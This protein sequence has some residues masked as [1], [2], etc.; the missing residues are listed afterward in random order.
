MPVGGCQ[1]GGGEMGGLASGS[2]QPESDS[3][4]DLTAD[5]NAERDGSCESG[6]PDLGVGPRGHAGGLL[7]RAEVGNR[8]LSWW[9][10]V[11]GWS[12]A[13][14]VVPVGRIHGGAGCTRSLSPPRSREAGS[15]LPGP[16][17]AALC[18]RHADPGTPAPPPGTALSR[19]TQAWCLKHGTQAWCL[20]H[21]T[22]AWRLKH[23]TWRRMSTKRERVLLLQQ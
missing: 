22:Q 5:R 16:G 9:R 14:G 7:A 18:T 13:P 1:W 17:G 15:R 20:K 4:S 12:S 23:G 2:T 10:S 8:Q 21:G 19:G 3:G 6:C 11:S